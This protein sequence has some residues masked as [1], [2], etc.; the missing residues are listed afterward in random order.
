MLLTHNVGI[1]LNLLQSLNKK[2]GDVRM[3]MTWHGP[4]VRNNTFKK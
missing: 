4:S 3:R 2:M 1:K